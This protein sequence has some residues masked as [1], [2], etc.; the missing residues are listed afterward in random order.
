MCV[1]GG[2]SVERYCPVQLAGAGVYF[3]T[4]A[5]GDHQPGES[6]FV[7]KTLIPYGHEDHSEVVAPIG[8]C[9]TEFHCLLLYRDR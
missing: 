3:G 2:S 4:L 8:M 6:L 1:G 7:E 9:L 5:F